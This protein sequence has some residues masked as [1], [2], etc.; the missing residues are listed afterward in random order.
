MG[1][2]AE[3]DEAALLARFGQVKARI[4][5]SVRAAGRA[6]GSVRLI[7]VSK[8]APSTAVLPL[9]AAGH[10]RFGENRVQEAASKWTDLREGWGDLQ[11]HMIG[12]LQSNK[13][14][15]AVSLF[16]VIET[17]D[18]PKLALA[19]S[20]AMRQLERRPL[21][22][23]EINIGA[24]PQKAGVLPQ[25]AD[26]FIDDCQRRWDLPLAGLMCIPPQHS[27]P[28]EAFHQLAEIAARHGLVELSMGM[29]EDFPQ[30]IAAGATMVRIGT[31][32]FGQRPD[33]PV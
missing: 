8:T 7:A 9:L 12:P 20:S 4:D 24:E 1:G 15:Q 28:D 19:L 22:F 25:E 17:V 18:R 21:C 16:D 11:L 27:A 29:S 30:A 10:R 14:L 3:G 33:K 6:P 13:V 5:D 32:I 26:Q 31:A 23:V 2:V